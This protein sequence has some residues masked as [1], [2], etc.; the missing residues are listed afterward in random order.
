[1]ESVMG[2]TGMQLLEDC[3]LQGSVRES[4]APMTWSA[5]GQP[6]DSTRSRGNRPHHARAEQKNVTDP[7]AHGEDTKKFRSA[8]VAQDS[9]RSTTRC[10]A[11]T[12]YA[13]PSDDDRMQPHG[14]TAPTSPTDF[15]RPDNRHLEASTRN[16]QGRQ[17]SCSREGD[18]PLHCSAQWQGAAA[19]HS[20]VTFDRKGREHEAFPTAYE[21]ED[22]HADPSITAMNPPYIPPVSQR[23][24][25]C[26]V[27]SHMVPAPTVPRSTQS[28]NSN[29]ERPA[30]TQR[31]HKPPPDAPIIASPHGSKT[32]NSR[33]FRQ[34]NTQPPSHMGDF[35]G[36]T[37]SIGGHAAH[38]LMSSIA[39]V[40]LGFP[41]TTHPMYPRQQDQFGFH[42][43]TH[44]SNTTAHSL[45][46]PLAES[47]NMDDWVGYDGGRS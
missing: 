24:N 37:A 44:P 26:P 38:P 14:Y 1:M 42:H 17:D 30:A 47:M 31:P 32:S 21:E 28:S 34:A 7:R 40:P 41:A 29:V 27:L 45:L 36:S 4:F 8:D 46:T 2:H 5:L 35:F 23:H 16:Y 19:T 9:N 10:S 6:T 20:A 3:G 13:T 15:S 33:P 11:P 12:R 22:R 39:E 25:S 43:P 18:R